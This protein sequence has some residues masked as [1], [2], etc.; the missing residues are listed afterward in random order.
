[1][2]FKTTTILMILLVVVGG[3][4][5][6]TQMN[7][8]A[9]PSPE[10]QT[11]PGQG[12]K[13]LDIDSGDVQ[14]ITITDSQGQRTSLSKMADAWK[15]TEPV[16]ATAVDWQTRDL[17]RTLCDLRSQGRPEN[18]PPDAGL[19]TP[20]YEVDLS[21]SDGKT[22]RLA[23]GNRTGV[24]DV[25]YAQ[26]DGGD[27]NLIDS[28]LAKTLKTAATDLRDKRLLSISTTDVKQV[29]ITTG[30]QNLTMIQDGGKWKITSPTELPGDSSAISSLISTITSTEATE[31]LPSNSDELAFAGFEHPTTQ[32]RLSTAAP[33]TAPS[34]TEPSDSTSQTLTIGAPDSLSKDHYFVET[35]D[36][37]FAKIAGTSLDN[38]K[39]TPMDLRDKNLVTI[40]PGDVTTIAL[41]KETYLSGATT[42]SSSAKPIS[43]QTV[44]LT[45]RPKVVTPMGPSIPSTRTST[46]QPQIAQSV[47]MFKIPSD[48]KAQVDDSKVEALLAKLNPLQADKF[49]AA[50]PAGAV[51]QRYVLSIDT[52]PAGSTSPQSYRVELIRPTDGQTPYASYNDLT[53]EIPASFLD[54]LDVDFHQTTP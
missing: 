6:Y 20:K 14:G 31:F 25:M 48:T 21:T 15:M 23:L 19:N 44:A 24:G 27:V 13:L 54:A 37:L 46:T 49:L 51:Q 12:Q 40:L 47:W 2:S 41:L 17:I 9:A 28:S 45:R 29:R 32:I 11:I 8:K 36:G 39:K 34:A 5:W 33:T 7:Q 16:N 3:I 18:A 52:Q 22:V 10:A 4:F 30:G 53:F 35:S 38:L 26:V 42:R 43:T 50:G 1:M